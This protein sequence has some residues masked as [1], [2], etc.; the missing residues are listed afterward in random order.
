MHSG[1]QSEPTVEAG[2]EP[3]GNRAHLYPSS[4]ASPVTGPLQGIRLAI[5]GMSEVATM[6][7]SRR[8][9]EKVRRARVGNRSG[10][11]R[12]VV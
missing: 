12:G 4:G 1:C 8:F 2:P 3:E 5:P 6:A 9:E 7:G 11:A 10:N